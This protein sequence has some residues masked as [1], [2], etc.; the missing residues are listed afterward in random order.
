MNTNY[1]NLKN[2]DAYNNLYYYNPH[3]SSL[4]DSCESAPSMQMDI[5]SQDSTN[6]TQTYCSTADSTAF[7]DIS[8]DDTCMT[9]SMPKVFC[10]TP[11]SRVSSDETEETSPIPFD[12]ETVKEEFSIALMTLSEFSSALSENIPATPSDR[13]EKLK[14]LCTYVPKNEPGQ[15]EYWNVWLEVPTSDNPAQIN[16]VIEEERF[17]SQ[18]FAESVIN[19]DSSNQ[20]IC[21]FI[22]A[23]IERDDQVYY[24]VIRI[25]PSFDT[26]EILHIQ[27]AENLR[28]TEVKKLCMMFLDYIY[29]TYTYLHDD[30]K[31]VIDAD[32]SMALRLFLPV[33]NDTPKTWYSGDGFELAEYEY[34]LN[35]DGQAKPSQNMHIY[36]SAITTVRGTLMKTLLSKEPSDH[37]FKKSVIES[38]IKK[39]VKPAHPEINVDNCTLHTIAKAIYLA[40]KEE[41]NP[42]LSKKAIKDFQNFYFHYLLPYPHFPK[43]YQEALNILDS[44]QLW[45]KTSY[46]PTT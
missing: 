22:K 41:T 39:Y 16:L 8:H 21:H 2:Y 5:A 10:N 35:F 9:D 40:S 11:S 32:S 7:T 23:S 34:L 19:T 46:T 33:V 43:P 12:T 44:Y 24:F 4:N 25:D 30:A 1:D 14:S 15:N 28:G 42:S 3:T 6:S 17:D 27:Q 31:I 45:F 20:L 13:L 18:C 26:A 38:W 36:Q 37:Y 29:P